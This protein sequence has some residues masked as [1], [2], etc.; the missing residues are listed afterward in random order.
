M[1]NNL[2]SLPSV[3]KLLAHEKIRELNTLLP[4]EIITDL[5]R[6]ALSLTRLEIGR[7]KAAPGMESIVENVCGQVLALTRPSLRPLVNATGVVLHTNLG[8]AP[9]SAEAVSA[10]QASSLEYNNLEFD[11]GSG[12][13][14]SRHIHVESLLCRLSGAEAALV[15]NNN[16]SA[17]MLGLTALAKRKEVVVSRGQAVEIGG[18][19]RIPEVMRQSGAKLVEV[20]TTNCTYLRDY[21]QAV[22]PRTA[23]LLRVHSSNFRVVGFTQMVSLEELVLLGKQ[24]QIPVLDDLGSGCPLDTAQFGLAAEPTIQ[25]A[26]KTGADLVFFSGDKLLGGPQAGI[27]AGKKVLVDKLKKHPLVRALRVDKTRLAGLAATLLHYL[28]GEALT[29]VPV[30]RMISL[31]PSE[32]ERR[33]ALWS[34]HFRGQARVTE[35]QS[36]IGGGSL[37]GAVLPTF[38]LAF[39]DPTRPAMAQ[40]MAARL[41]QHDPPVIGRISDNLLLLDPRTVFPEQDTEVI[42]ALK[43]IIREA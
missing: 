11:L 15:V 36:L 43:H 40:K 24:Y 22:T 8:R 32:I 25:Q 38:L 41:R 20:G 31:S 1:D 42:E 23:A 27:I 7:G 18:G 29:K 19:F 39:G 35:G 30:W 33:A 9:L 26:V 13:R 28:K 12:E 21:E 5:V 34:A 14:G 4:R 16:A 10:M 6:E 17:V 2:R 37:P 3:D